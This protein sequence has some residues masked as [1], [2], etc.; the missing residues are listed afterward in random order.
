[1]KVITSFADPLASSKCLFI[2]CLLNLPRRRGVLCQ[3][4][5]SVPRE[6]HVRF[7]EL[8]GCQTNEQEVSI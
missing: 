8:V 6:F 4:R 1:M 2:D 7:Y 5:S 3:Y